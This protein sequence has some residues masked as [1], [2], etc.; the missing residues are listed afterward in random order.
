M[1]DPTLSVRD[2]DRS[3]LEIYRARDAP[4]LQDTDMMQ[5]AGG[6][7]SAPDGSNAEVP[8]YGDRKHG[9]VVSVLFRQAGDGGLSVIHAWL[10]PQ[11]IISRHS[12]NTDC[13]YYVVFGEAILGSHVLRAGD[14]FFVPADHPYA[15]SAGPEGA[16]ILEFRGATS[17]D[18]RNLE[19]PDGWARLLASAAANR[20]RWLDETVP[21]SW[22]AAKVGAA[23]DAA[24]RSH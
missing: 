8:D 14:G 11:F 2:A 9:A 19:K 10:K 6:G 17:F 5:Y 1:G 7:R 3:R 21:P 22:R 12:H 23:A 13:L 4:L 24:S 20:P 15:Y 16:E 18:I